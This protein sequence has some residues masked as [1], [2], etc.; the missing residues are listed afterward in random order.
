MA[1]VA[2]S[3]YFVLTSQYCMHER[4]HD[5][6]MLGWHSGI[7]IHLFHAKL[8]FWHISVLQF[9]IEIWIVNKITCWLT[10]TVLVTSLQSASSRLLCISKLSNSSLSYHL[11]VGLVFISLHCKKKMWAQFLPFEIWTK[12]CLV[13]LSLFRTECSSPWISVHLMLLSNLLID[14]STLSWQ[15]EMPLE[16]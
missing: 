13:R 4:D 12:P 16:L 2:R 6:L 10:S 15:P 7:E 1:K 8:L 11:V 5:P 9:Y 3:T 14:R